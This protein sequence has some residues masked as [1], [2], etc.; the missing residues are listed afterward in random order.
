MRKCA[1]LVLAFA[2]LIP[3]LAT[4][5]GS[6]EEKKFYGKWEG[7]WT[8]PNSEVSKINGAVEFFEDGTFVSWDLFSSNNGTWVMGKKGRVKVDNSS[9]DY[10][11]KGDTLTLTAGEVKYSLKKQR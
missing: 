4:C 3:L 8:N 1:Y 10:E 2:L 9:Y 11:I 6:G 5:S 7:T